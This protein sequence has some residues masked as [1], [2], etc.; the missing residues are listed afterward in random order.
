MKS[1]KKAQKFK[2]IIN[3]LN[4]VPVCFIFENEV[5]RL[6]SLGI[7]FFYPFLYDNG[8]KENTMIINFLQHLFKRA[9]YTSTLAYYQKKILLKKFVWYTWACARPALSDLTRAGNSAA[10]ASSIGSTATCWGWLVKK[11]GT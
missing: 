9:N 3:L 11:E 4:E 2:D 8:F 5:L 7:E 6:Q 10:A 1:R